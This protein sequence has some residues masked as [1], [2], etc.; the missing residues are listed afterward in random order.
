[1]KK[2]EIYE[3]S[4]AFKKSKDH[5]NLHS[6]VYDGFDYG[7]VS[8]INSDNSAIINWFNKQITSTEQIDDL[9]SV[10]PRFESTKIHGEIWKGAYP[11]LFHILDKGFTIIV[12]PKEYRK[13]VTIGDTVVIT[14]YKLLYE[15]RNQLQCSE[16]IITDIK[17]NN[18]L[19]IDGTKGCISIAIEVKRCQVS[20]NKKQDTFVLLDIVCQTCNN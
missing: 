5:I 19:V 7:F 17:D 18:N 20:L 2:Q 16:F 12:K 13:P 6:F 1:M 8:F 14:D 4:I 11:I 15:R 9:I 10:R 3:G